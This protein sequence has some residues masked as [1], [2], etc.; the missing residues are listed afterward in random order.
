VLGL[1]GLVGVSL[2][3]KWWDAD[4][5]SK[6]DYL[7]AWEHDGW[8]TLGSSVFDVGTLLTGAG[9]VSK[10]GDAVRL[11]RGA[12]LADA[13]ADGS[14]DSLRG[15]TADELRAAVKGLSAADA[16]KLA[17]ELAKPEL[18]TSALSGLKLDD[19]TIHEPVPTPD[20]VT[21]AD[22]ATGA[23]P[24]PHAELRGPAA[25]YPSG[26]AAHPGL[27]AHTPVQAGA[28]AGG[29][30][31]WVLRM[32]DGAS[33]WAKYQA[34]IAGLDLPPG[35]GMLEYKVVGATRSVDFDGF[36]LRG[37]P[38]VQ[39]YLDAKDGY[40][41]SFNPDASQTLRNGASTRFLEQAERQLSVVPDDAMVEWHFSNPVAAAEVRRLF[42]VNDVPIDVYY[43][44]KVR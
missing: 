12:T 7:T 11:G 39:V 42:Q 43:T 37:E 23:E 40:W 9:A 25:S 18:D 10:I 38:P 31:E 2:P 14:I 36:A 3:A 32:R 5:W 1:T 21:H 17:A 27:P 8:Q 29:V 20:P 22:P 26:D 6:N 41:K 13:V 24:L 44:P 4:A 33:A 28:H 30:G 16:E 34:Q 35:G 15:L 19:L